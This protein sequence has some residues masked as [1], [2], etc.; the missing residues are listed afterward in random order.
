MM[1][2]SFQKQLKI[3]QKIKIIIDTEGTNIIQLVDGLKPQH[4]YSLKMLQD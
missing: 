4:R 2:I 1:F 3:M